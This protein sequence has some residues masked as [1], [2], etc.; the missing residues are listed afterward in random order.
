MLSKDV[1]K[2][3]TCRNDVII[4]GVRICRLMTMPC[5]R[6]ERCPLVSLAF[7]IEKLEIQRRNADE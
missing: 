2:Q 6:V 5:C 3:E 4:D 7:G 1:N